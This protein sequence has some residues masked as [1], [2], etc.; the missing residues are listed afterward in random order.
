MNPLSPLAQQSKGKSNVRLAVISIIAL[1]AVFFGGL[2]LQGCKPKTTDS[3]LAG[4]G[5]GPTTFTN[6]LPPLN[7]TNLPPFGSDAP[8]P[9]LAGQPAQPLTP[10]VPTNGAWAPSTLPPVDSFVP[11]PPASTTE[12]VVKSGDF[13]A[14]IAKDH[15][16]ALSA[17][18]QAN[19]G[20][21]PTKLKIGQKL[22]IPA[23][24]AGGGATAAGTE[25]GAEK[26]LTHV[27]KAG[28]NLTKIAKTYGV[29]IKELRAAN[30]LKTDRINVGQKL[31]VP[32]GKPAP[33]PGDMGAAT[34]A[35][36]RP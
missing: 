6:D 9:G 32:G 25:P 18:M 12:Y 26:T 31:K 15:G 21:E 1:H 3:S 20:L 16:V 10:S 29:T 2:L 5:G 19:P 7:Q 14:R 30:N 24:A 27:V 22:Q 11:V 8:P 13:P 4:G 36:P 35:A 34:T 28:D 33:A 23:P 17:L